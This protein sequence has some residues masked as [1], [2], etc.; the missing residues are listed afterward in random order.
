M[1]SVAINVKGRTDMKRIISILII[2][3]VI[4]FIGCTSKEDS[5]INSLPAKQQKAV[6]NS[7]EFIKNSSFSSKNSIDTGII[8][9]ENAKE[10]TWKWVCTKDSPISDN[11][12][13]TTDWIITLGSTADHSFAIIICDSNTSEVLGY[14]PIK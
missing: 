14:M 3:N 13:D 5:E 12:V 9:V 8:K 7:I 11:A 10:D 6:K 1:F 4:L 2:I